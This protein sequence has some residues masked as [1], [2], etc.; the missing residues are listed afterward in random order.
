MDEIDR[1]HRNFIIPAKKKRKKATW[2][3]GFRV[4]EASTDIDRVEYERMSRVL[5]YR[6]KIIKSK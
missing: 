4:A 5:R 6:N 2:C 1:T 3:D